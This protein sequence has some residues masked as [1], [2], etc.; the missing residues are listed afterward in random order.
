[1]INT[2]CGTELVDYRVMT[3]VSILE[4]N[5]SPSAKTLLKVFV[6]Q[7]KMHTRKDGKVQQYNKLSSLSF[8]FP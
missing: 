7:H 8:K 3:G 1:V 4:A 2:E 6:I 5:R